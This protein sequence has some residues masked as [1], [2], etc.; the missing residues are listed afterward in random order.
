[1]EHFFDSREA[2]SI[3][4][5]NRLAD[6]LQ[7]RLDKQDEASI[8]VSGGTTPSQCF[9][10]LSGVP[11]DWRR[12]HVVLSDERWVPVDDASSNEAMV[13]KA[14]LKNRAAHAHI[15][16]MYDGSADASTRCET[17]E[18]AIRALPFPFA[19]ALIGMGE[20]GHFASLFPDFKDLKIGL[21]VDYPGL[22]LP[23]S[24]EA[25]PH[26]RISLTLAA[27]SRSDEVVLLFFGDTKREV[28][29]HAKLATNGFPVSR[30]LRQKRAPVRV[31]WA[32]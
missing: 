14:L 10:E 22:C 6:A 31:Y 1:M 29:E 24:T 21:D 23:V 11:L 32:P 25:S 7:R 15:L 17:L 18:E 12:V 2:A 3:A 26:P 30:L 27:I 8:I 28:Y 9:E 5:A 4:A 13:R 16:P 20:D 19:T